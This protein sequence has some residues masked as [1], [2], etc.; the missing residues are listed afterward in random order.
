MRNDPA[1]DSAPKIDLLRR[2]FD[3]VFASPD[4]EKGEE[5]EN[6]LAIRVSGDPYGLSVREIQ[7]VMKSVP[8]LPLRSR[9]PGFLGIAGYRG[10]I[11]P[12][13]R[14]ST[15]L[16]H[17]ASREAPRWLAVCG[18][19][20]A[21]ALAFE[22]LEGYLLVPGKSFYTPEASPRKHVDRFARI[23]ESARGIIRVAPVLD[24]IRGRQQT[25]AGP[26][27]R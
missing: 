7:A 13:Y 14:L 19:R 20:D 2:E 27:P 18:E 1:V 25:T 6:I 9:S 5:V 22:V 26:G 8:V 23:G 12:V 10:G 17:E 11:L 15:L 3:R 21:I 16:G 4:R 24:A